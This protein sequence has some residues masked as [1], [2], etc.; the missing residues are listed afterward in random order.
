M[1]KVK[2]FTLLELLIVVAVLGILV[3]L[4]LPRFADVR[5]DANAKVCTANLRG[6]ASAMAIY[7]TRQNVDLEW[8]TRAVSDLLSWDYVA[9]EPYCPYE[10]GAAKT[11]YS[12]QT[13]TPDQATCPRVGTYPD[14]KWP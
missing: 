12:L 4:I 9:K 5:T 11:A 7:E 2:G 8:N 10:T 14:H 13:G 3:A 1:K 6:L